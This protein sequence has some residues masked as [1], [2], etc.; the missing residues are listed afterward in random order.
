MILCFG[1]DYSRPEEADG[2]R[3]WKG[4][5]N[6]WPPSANSVVF[7]P[8]GRRPGCGKLASGGSGSGEGIN[9]PAGFLLVQDSGSREMQS[10]ESGFFGIGDEFGQSHADG[11]R[12]LAWD[13]AR[14]CQNDLARR[15]HPQ[16]LGG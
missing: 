2:I 13:R 6:V 10:Y 7:R 8:A 12:G 4:A 16:G 5:S 15:H 11:S 1:S 9:L 3:A 14:R